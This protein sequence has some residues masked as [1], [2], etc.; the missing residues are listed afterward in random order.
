M[1]ETM[2]NESIAK[3]AEI[4]EEVWRPRDAY[5]TSKPAQSSLM[6]ARYAE[7][8]NAILRLSGQ[9]GE[10]PEV[11]F[12][13]VQLSIERNPCIEENTLTENLHWFGVMREWNWEVRLG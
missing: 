10:C 5:Q 8:W 6:R 13:S 9:A 3:C 4:L 2:P 11:E 1:A 12:E 7:F